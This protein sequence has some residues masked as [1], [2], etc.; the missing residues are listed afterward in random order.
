MNLAELY[1]LT[2]G[3]KLDKIHTFE[4][5]YP[6]PFD[7]YIILQPFSKASKN[8]DYIEEVISLILP[9]LEKNNIKIVQ[10]GGPNE[11]PL[12]GCYHT[13]GNTSW[14]QLQYLISKSKLVLSTDS[15]SSH[16]AGHYNKSLV[17]LIS[18]NFKECISPYYG[19]KSK[20]II[21]E[22]DR[23]KKNPSFMLD[24]G[25]IKQIN[26]I[27]PE[28]IAKSVL[29][30]LNIN[31]EYPYKTLK[32]GPAYHQK[33]IE[34]SCSDVINT[35]QL[36]VQNIILRLDY[37]YNLP[38]L[39]NQLNITK[40]IIFTDKSIPNDILKQYRPN[41]QEII[42]EI[43]EDN[44]PGF[45]KN[46]LNNKIPYKLYSKL[47]I[48]KLNPIKL[49]YLDNPQIIWHKEYKMPEELKN[50]DIGSGQIWYKSNKFL[51]S[52]GK[53][54]QSFYDLQNNRPIPSFVN[55]PQQIIKENLEDLWPE[56]DNV[57]FLEKV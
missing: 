20:Q 1:S 27:Y 50:K 45:V 57:L 40:C 42:Y 38:V 54:Y 34:S 28:T 14:G 4:K 52:G 37:N 51:L 7:N 10:V 48:E 19:D 26:E 49:S 30:L 22:P 39:I 3:Q 23:T 53:I 43:K 21:L 44:D 25:P 13:Q 17:V 2:S 32:I 16:L 46:L 11:R 47:P 31:F 41:I 12:N 56:I 9:E 55:I 36:G 35:Q 5:Y 15:V 8:Y 6:L 18:N 24:E 33:L 29:N